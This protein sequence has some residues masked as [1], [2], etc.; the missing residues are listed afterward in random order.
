MVDTKKHPVYIINAFVWQV[1]KLNV[2]LKESDYGESTVS[3]RVPIVPSGQDAALVAINKPFLVYGY[4]E[5]STPDVYAMR[6]GSV[7][8]AVWSTSVGE[9]NNILNTIRSAMERRD[10]SAA[11]VNRW[12]TNNP[13]YLGIRFGD[14]AVGYLE[15]P[16]PEETEGGRHA[17]II[18]LRYQYF[19]DYDV[20][21]PAGA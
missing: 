9:V 13:S 21:L 20:V 10:E 14:I 16:A 1:L 17:G 4:S 5:D 18:T 3:G 15:G 6:G 2:G 11:A 7:S 12:S 19:A 8:Y